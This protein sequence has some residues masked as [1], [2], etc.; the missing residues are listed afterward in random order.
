MF[1]RFTLIT[2]LVLIASLGLATMPAVGSVETGQATIVVDA[3]EVTGAIRSLQGINAGPRGDESGYDPTP[4]PTPRSRLYL[5]LILKDYIPTTPTPT[6]TPTSTPSSGGIVLADRPGGLEL[7]SAP[8]TI[9]ITV[10]HVTYLPV[11]VQGYHRPI[12]VTAQ[13]L[14][15][16]Y[17]ND[18]TPDEPGESSA[19]VVGA[20]ET[21]QSKLKLQT[22]R[23][24]PHPLTLTFQTRKVSE[25]PSGLS[26]TL[27]LEPSIQPRAPLFGTHP[28]PYYD[29]LPQPYV[30]LWGPDCGS[31]PT[32]PGDPPGSTRDVGC[33]KQEFYFLS[34]ISDRPGFGWLADLR[35]EARPT[36][37]SAE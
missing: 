23:M 21:P 32:K 31:C 2:L 17:V 7:V 19:F 8:A 18:L 35:D 10:G 24:R 28:P 36:R 15:H 4:T 26:T 16:T 20:L 1:R 27:T 9:P 3:A 29:V 13:A 25:N 33:A 11:E 12:T 22:L 14:I 6:P 30:P 37:G 5:P 34:V